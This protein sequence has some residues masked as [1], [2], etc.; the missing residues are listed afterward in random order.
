MLAPSW[1]PY[2]FPIVSWAFPDIVAQPPQVILVHI[3]V[4]EEDHAIL[5]AA[6]SL[7]ADEYVRQSVQF[8][9][10]LNQA[11]GECLLRG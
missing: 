4:V 1:Y 3:Q 9:L 8:D 11:G 2:T 10:A 6:V 5:T 7:D